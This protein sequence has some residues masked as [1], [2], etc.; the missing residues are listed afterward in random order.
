MIITGECFYSSPWNFNDPLD[1]SYSLENFPEEIPEDVFGRFS[2]ENAHIPHDLFSILHKKRRHINSGV[3]SFSGRFSDG[4]HSDPFLSPD[5]WGHYADDHKGIC[6]GFS[7][8]STYTNLDIRSS[9]NPVREGKFLK[10]DVPNMAGSQ[11]LLSHITSRPHNFDNLLSAE[12]SCLVKVQYPDN[13]LLPE[14]DWKIVLENYRKIEK[15]TIK[16]AEQL[17][18][19]IIGNAIDTKMVVANKHKNWAVENEYRLFGSAGKSQTIGAAI[20]SVTFGLETNEDSRKYLT[21]LISRFYGISL[22]EIYKMELLN[23]SLTRIPLE[24]N[25]SSP[26]SSQSLARF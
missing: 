4:S 19:S 16:S 1:C 6:I 21:S 7:P 18:N 17:L 2:K 23:G 8:N 12:K 14:P 25:D 5:V 15:T 11:N 24:M 20:S 22:V 10:F 13:F 26:S 3:V 9:L